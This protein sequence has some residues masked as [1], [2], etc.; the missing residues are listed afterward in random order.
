MLNTNKMTA[1]E[2]SNGLY[3]QKP[4][5][6]YLRA[7]IESKRNKLQKKMLFNFGFTNGLSFSII[8]IAK[9]MYLFFGVIL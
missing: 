8:M 7:E 4:F 1:E 3:K 6:S 9:A 5:I 2:F